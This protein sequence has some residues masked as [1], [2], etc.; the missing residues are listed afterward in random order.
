VSCGT[1]DI[2]TRLEHTHRA[3]R[4]ELARLLAPG[5]HEAAL[6]AAADRVR[7]MAVG[8]E[9]HLRALIEFSNRCWRN[10]LYCGL[11][12][13]HRELA[14]YRMTPEEILDAVAAAAGLGYRTVVLQ[15]GEDPWYA[16][17]L[18]AYLLR[19]IKA[20]HDVAVTLAIGERPEDDYRLLRE[21]GADRFLLRME[22]SAPELYREMHPE[23]AWEGTGAGN[24]SRNCA[25]IHTQSPFTQSPF[26]GWHARLE[27]LHALR[28]LGYQVGS[29]VMIGLPGQSLEVLADDLLSLQSLDLDMIGV[30]P[31]IPHPATPLR[32]AAGGTLELSLRFIAC[33]RLLCPEAHIPATT[34]LGALDPQGRKRALQAGANVLMPNCTPVEYRAR[35]E[36][37]PGKI[38][39]D[40]SA[41]QCRGCVEAMVALLGR[42]VG[43]GYG[44]SLRWTHVPA[45]VGR[46][47]G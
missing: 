45:P 14:R 47:T 21:A 2:L 12:R 15:S 37:Y 33:L 5:E 17:P 13:D 46:D 27:C 44:H 26:A 23:A 6:L 11:R 20:R 42:T 22:T 40:E 9:V 35:Y 39:T 29:G 8:D 31:F 36:L 30:G 18:L 4:E 16:A 34:A 7:Q 1:V 25:E 38:C 43:K 19:T 41:P 28:R 10:C 32:D 3:S 24:G